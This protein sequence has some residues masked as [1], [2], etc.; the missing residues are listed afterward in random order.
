MCVLKVYSDTDS[1]K[2]YA[3]NTD[4]PVSSCLDK[5]EAITPRQLCEKHRIVFN[6]SDREWNEFNEQV[7]DAISFLEKY[8]TELKKLFSTHSISDAYLDFPLRSKLDGNIAVQ[9]EYIPRELTKLTGKLNIGICM[10]VYA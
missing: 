7:N 8:N 9:N 6:V 10:A 3:N 2:E 5:A 1:F 4:M